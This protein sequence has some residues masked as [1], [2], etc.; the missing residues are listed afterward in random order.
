MTRQY[1]FLLLLIISYALSACTPTENDPATVADQYWQLL[2]S[3]DTVKAKQ[4]LSTSG[5]QAIA[6]HSNR[7]NKNTHINSS[8]ARTTV[9]TTITTTNPV[10]GYRH[11]ESFDTVLVLE[12]GQWKVDASQ[13]HIP[14]E[15]SAQEQRAEQLADDL[16]Q[17]MKKNIDSIDNAMSEGMQLLNDAFKNGSKEMNESL[18]HLMDKLNNTMQESI[19]K[20]KQRRQQQQN[21]QNPPNPDKGEGM[22]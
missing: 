5:Q 1:S 16:S 14:P 19:D 15:P 7:I 2:Q 11:T 18:L 13:T 9:Q 3:G 10:S 17:S 8:K 20:M 21:K 4:L 22:I 12:Q 6:V